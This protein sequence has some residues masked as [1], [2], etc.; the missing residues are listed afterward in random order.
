MTNRAPGLIILLICGLTLSGC[1]PHRPSYARETGDLNY[2]VDQ[3]TEIAYP[4]LATPILEEVTQSLP[5]IT[6]SEA[7]FESF[8]DLNL[9]DTVAIALQNSKVIRGYG[10]PGLQG[11]NVSPGIDNLA[12]GPNGAGTI[13]D[14]AVRESEPGFIGTPGQINPPGA[15]LTNTGLDANQGVEAALSDFD[16]QLTSNLGWVKTDRPNNVDAT[17]SQ[18]RGFITDRDS[19]NWTTQI[20]KR[21][22]NGSQF[23]A[24][25]T[26]G[27]T[28]DNPIVQPTLQPLTSVY[29]A[30]LEF[31]VRQPLLRGRGT[32]INRMPV[33]V[34]RINSDQA[35]AN[36]E[37]VMQNMVTNVEI[38]YWDLHRAYRNVETAKQ[39]RDA[40]LETWRTVNE[41]YIAGK[42][43][44]QDESQARGQYFF[45]RAQVERSWAELLQEE[46]NLRW[47]MGVASTDGRLIRPVDEP[48]KARVTFDYYQT[49]DEALIYRPELRQGRWE[50]KKRELACQY[51]KNSL[52][53]TLNASYLYRFLGLGDQFANYD[54]NAPPF[55][56]PNV[57]ATPGSGALN[58]LFDNQFN[59][60]QF[61]L[62]FGMPVGY[63]RELANVRNAQLKLARELARVQDMELD[64]EREITQAIQ[65]LEANY[66]LAQTN[67]NS[68]AAYS[69]E[70]EARKERYEAGTDPITFLLDAQRTRAQAEAEYYRAIC[71]YNKLIALIHRRKGTILAYNSIN[72]TEGPWPNKAYD[73]AYEYARK[74]SASKPL[75]YGFTRPQVISQGGAYAAEGAY[76][77]PVYEPINNAPAASQEPTPATLEEV[78]AKANPQL[79]PPKTAPPQETLPAP[80]PSV[81]GQDTLT[82]REQPAYSNVVYPKPLPRPAATAKQASGV[83]WQ[84]FGMSRPD[85]PNS[86]ATRAII[87]QVNYEEPIRK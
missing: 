14:V 64:V 62:D 74:R 5:P 24:R 75:N 87:R 46:T 36:F 6:N 56:T 23:F 45:F 77:M 12:N 21:A 66:Q 11:T 17:G 34:S 29:E 13:Y 65:S 2:F 32:F 37:A 38:R 47:L 52:L 28:R 22:A 82:I 44:L 40:A 84:R 57:G 25:N 68:W 3:A 53:P 15:I 16:A 85:T 39:G 70:L 26:L 49:M 41:N 63:R 20:G 78:P 60:F 67:F 10:T 76:E 71:E 4:D 48:T 18:L 54:G 73:D 55:A 19:V 43:P 31:E 42:V 9:E 83:N 35:I 72:L 69:A 8:W 7:K 80:V 58:D 1:Q 81:P 30:A 51:S 33:I 50:V 27:Y 61:N 79:N 59:E 86:S